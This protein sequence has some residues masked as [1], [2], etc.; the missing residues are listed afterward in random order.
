MDRRES[1]VVA[2]RAESGV[3]SLIQR[4]PRSVLSLA[5]FALAIRVSYVLIAAP[6]HLPFTD[7]LGY[8][9]QAND[10]ASGHG[11]VNP[12][13]LAVE[14]VSRP[15]AAHPPLYALFL[16]A[17]S[18]L[19]AKSVLA[20][21]LMGC[22]IGT[23]T[24]VGCGLIAD[25][26]EGDR[27][28]M[29]A[30]TVAALYPGLWITDG[31]VMSEGLF[32]FLATAVTLAAYNYSRVRSVRAAINLGTSIGLA[33]LT[34]DAAEI[35]LVVLVVPLVLTGPAIGVRPR[36]VRLLS[37]FAA[38]GVVVSPWVLRNLV[39][40]DRP[41]IISTGNGTLLGANC[42]P[43]YFGGGIGQWYQSCY[44]SISIPAGADESVSN[45]EAQ[46]AGVTYARDHLS[47]LPLVVAA[48]IGRTWELYQPLTDTNSN[49]DDGRPHWAALLSLWSYY[50]V[51]LCAAAGMTHL[52]QRHKPVL[53]LTAQFAAVIITSATVWGSV[54]FRAPAEPI[55]AALAAIAVCLGFPGRR[56]LT[57]NAQ[58][59]GSASP[60]SSL[61]RRISR[62]MRA[63]VATPRSEA[64]EGE[65]QQAAEGNLADTW[66][67]V[68]A[69]PAAG[70]AARAGS[71]LPGEDRPGRL[72]RRRGD[73]GGR[74]IPRWQ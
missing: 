22:L 39:T 58:S 28:A 41:V 24:V 38:A 13:L 52:I 36:L 8:Q 54:R 74:V 67:A 4:R 45:D 43:A 7:A 55:L 16:A 9:L 56:P 63:V 12:L 31:G 44:N 53:P 37:A 50:P 73:R 26:L 11:F 20:H 68:F 60:L 49:R 17:G 42:P 19:G 70:V 3:F 10:L 62:R 2:V 47:R 5:F 64:S 57:N 30:M 66:E 59:G 21:Q 48:R 1:L 71:A 51:L 32:A 23:A 65:T 35:L 69:G 46:H 34:R 18:V 61:R 6:R 15:T 25:Q 14:H 40:F 72:E 33:V 27:A 29:A